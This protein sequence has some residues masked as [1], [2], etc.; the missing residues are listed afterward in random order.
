M[1]KNVITGIVVVL[2]LLVLGW[3]YWSQMM[4]SAL[5]PTDSAPLESVNGSA[6][7]E[8]ETETKLSGTWQS[9]EDTKFTREFR[10]D[11]T[12]TDRY[13]GM[14]DAMVTGTWSFVDPALEPVALPVVKDARV[15]KIEFPEEA[16]YFALT[17]VSETDL[18]LLYLSGNGTLEFTKI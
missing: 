1:N 2:A 15:L 3:W 16:L 9:K 18:T 5:A 13:E 7:Q 17:G 4:P 14:T 10:S 12:V 8:E 11:G 6:M